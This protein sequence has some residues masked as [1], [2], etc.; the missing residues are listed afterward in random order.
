MTDDLP[1]RDLAQDFLWYAEDAGDNDR[2]MIPIHRATLRAAARELEAL[3]AEVK[4][5]R[6]ALERIAAEENVYKGHG[7]Y[8]VEPALSATEAQDVAREALKP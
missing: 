7:D 2:E 3:R 5:L 4:R 8:T 6:E 1:K